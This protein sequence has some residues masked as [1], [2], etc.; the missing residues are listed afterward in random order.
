MEHSGQKNKKE[1]IRRSKPS[2][3]LYMGIVAMVAVFVLFDCTSSTPAHT[4]QSVASAQ[5]DS[6]QPWGN[7]APPDGVPPMDGAGGPPPDGSGGPEGPGGPGGPGGGPMAKAPDSYK[8]V[9]VQN[10]GDKTL[11]GGS[12]ET[13]AVDT[14]AIVVDKK[15]VFH[16][17]NATIATSGKTSSNDA[18]SFY[19]LNAA[20]LAVNGSSVDLSKSNISTTGAG[21]NG[22]FATGEGSIV[23]LKDVS[24]KA[25]GGGG[26]AVMATRG[27][28]MILDN[29]D[30][31]TAGA[32][33]GAIATDRGSGT[34]IVNGG[35]VHTSGP[36]SPAVYSTGNITVSNAKL[37]ASGSEAAVIE[38]ANTITL[39]NSELSSTKDGKWGVMV[40][41]SFS[42]DAEGNKGIYTTEGGSLSYTGTKGP[43]FFV[44]NTNAFIN[45]KGVQITTGSNVLLKAAADRWG[46]HGQNGGHANINAEGV[47]L[48]GAVVA[49][50]ISTVKILLS[51]QSVLHAMVN[52]ERTA[53]DVQ[54]T[55]DAFSVWN[56]EGDSW[57]TTLTE[58]GGTTAATLSNINGKG[59]TVHYLSSANPWL[60]GATIP[61]SGG[62]ALTPY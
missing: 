27:G 31:D 39:K 13:A 43:L 58:N 38:G 52:A 50:N 34:I 12:Y 10:G 55:L 51:K 41:Q 20:V 37:S 15:G 59:H 14:S 54:I 21:A 22:A 42:G 53:K 19:G 2:P 36:D 1:V 57:I 5:P 17:S 35:K 8:A 30:M 56:V 29:V 44:T 33:S 6:N 61:L 26:H 9:Y 23:T 24:I 62:G 25:T 47:S 32:N 40:Y 49:D 11:S 28:K 48:S 18:S 16:L 7:G 45:L 4:A 60:G 3:W 46:R